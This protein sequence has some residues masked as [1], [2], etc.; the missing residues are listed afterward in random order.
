DYLPHR[1]SD[2]WSDAAPAFPQV[3]SG[4]RPTSKKFVRHMLKDYAERAGIEKPIYPHMMRKS[5]GTELTMNNPKLGQIHLG[6]KSIR[7]TLDHYSMPDD[8]DKETIN[9]VIS[10]SLEDRA[11]R[12]A[13][14][15]DRCVHMLDTAV[16]PDLTQPLTPKGTVRVEGYTGIP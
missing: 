3:K 1:D 7:T 11:E 12:A 6:H 8:Q 10:L 5:G 4:G 9:A 16:N 13:A 14:Q 15:L 2:D